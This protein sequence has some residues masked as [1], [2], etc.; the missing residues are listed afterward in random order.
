MKQQSLLPLAGMA[1]MALSLFP[2]IG[3]ELLA[4]SV[5]IYLQVSQFDSLMDAELC[6][7]AFQ[8]T[9]DT[10][11]T[12][13]AGYVTAD[14]EIDFDPL[15]YEVIDIYEIEFTGGLISTTEDLTF[16]LDFSIAGSIQAVITDI[17]GTLATPSPPGLVS[18][19]NF[20]MN[21]HVLIL[22]DGWIDGEATGALAGVLEPFS[23]AL[24]DE[25]LESTYNDIGSITA[26]L[27]NISG[28]DITY[29]VYLTLPVYF[30]TSFYENDVEF[31][32]VG[33]GILDATGQFTR[34]IPEP[35]TLLLLGLGAFMLLRKRRT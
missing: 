32:F 35:A 9:C 13:V 6:A 1:F 5:P 19:G 20:N 23:H 24:F 11:A 14:L 10:D 21:E 7:T 30:D 16:D 33:E 25:P 28:D 26:S 18:G 27:N 8:T 2:S 34:I 31:S 4:E 29:D 22:N 12:P 15:I 17:S 3:T